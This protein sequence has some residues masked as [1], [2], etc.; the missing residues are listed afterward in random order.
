MSICDDDKYLADANRGGSTIAVSN[1]V[2]KNACS[3]TVYI[4]EGPVLNLHLITATTTTPGA[5]EIQD[6]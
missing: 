2:I 1:C 6:A 3:A 4:L 5:S